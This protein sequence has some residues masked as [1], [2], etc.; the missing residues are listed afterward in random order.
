M[1]NQSARR[2]GAAGVTA[3]ALGTLGAATLL[4]TS[5][6]WGAFAGDTG[7]G[8]V[9]PKAYQG[10]AAAVGGDGNPDSAVLR[11]QS[12]LRERGYYSGPLD[13]KLDSRTTAAIK[14]YQYDKGLRSDGRLD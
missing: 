9:N 12:L 8:A 6:G 11:A 10:A 14:Q 7:F 3:R 2:T 5:T 13:G 4:L 1:I